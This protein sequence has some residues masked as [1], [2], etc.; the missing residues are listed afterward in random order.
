MPEWLEPFNHGETEMRSTLMSTIA[1]AAMMAPS[2]GGMAASA[3]PVPVSTIT[4]AGKQFEVRS[5]YKAGVIELTEGEAHTLN[6]TRHENIRN[7]FAKK[8]KEAKPEDDLQALISKYDGEYEFGVRGEGTGVSRDPIQVEARSLARA[9]IRE[10]LKAKGISADAKAINA[11]VEK[12]LA[13]EKGQ[14]FIEVAKQ[15]VAEKQAIAQ[16]ASDEMGD[17]LDSI[18]EPEAPAAGEAPAQVTDPDAQGAVA[19]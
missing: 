5:P 19:Q 2:D 18:N 3:E 9:T 15:R 16:Q 7:N 4:I 14:K 12:L 1:F 10:K 17:V 13:S 11:A 6:Q 8:V